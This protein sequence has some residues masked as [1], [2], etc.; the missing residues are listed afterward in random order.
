MR[1]DEI[2]E[3][4]GHMI[5]E[6]HNDVSVE[7][8]LLSLGGECFSHLTTNTPYDARAGHQCKQSLDSVTNGPL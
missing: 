8:M 6:M 7:P 5:S 2:G 3:F 4:T 1:H